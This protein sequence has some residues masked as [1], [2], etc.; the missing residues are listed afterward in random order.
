MAP[1]VYGQWI[2][3]SQFRRKWFPTNLEQAQTAARANIEDDEAEN[4]VIDLERRTE[5]D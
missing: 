3:W 5:F 2:S 4:R 1:P